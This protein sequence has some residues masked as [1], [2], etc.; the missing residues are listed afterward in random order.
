LTVLNISG[1]IYEVGVISKYAK[2][3]VLAES[4]YGDNHFCETNYFSHIG[5]L[6]ALQAD[7]WIVKSV[8]ENFGTMFI[9]K[10]VVCCL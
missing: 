9:A 10:N 6:V 5:S 1:D 3:D 8:S 7:E 4:H 2:V